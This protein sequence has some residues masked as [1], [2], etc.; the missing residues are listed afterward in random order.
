M[1]AP[2]PQPYNNY[3]N[4]NSVSFSAAVNFLVDNYQNDRSGWFDRLD[5]SGARGPVLRTN[6]AS[7]GAR[8]LHSLSRFVTLVWPLVA[9][10]GPVLAHGPLVSKR[11]ARC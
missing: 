4:L 10:R 2:A 1:S 7:L 8:A 5:P 6:L 9:L 3:T 11:S